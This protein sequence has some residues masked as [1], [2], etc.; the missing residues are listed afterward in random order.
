MRLDYI[1]IVLKQRGVPSQLINRLITAVLKCRVSLVWFSQ[2][3]RYYVKSRGVKQGCPVSPRVFIMMVDEVIQ[4]LVCVLEEIYGIKLEIFTD[5]RATLKAP[6]LMAYADD[7]LLVCEELQ[8]MDMIFKEL[9]ELLSSIGLNL[10]A[11]KTKL[12][13][14]DPMQGDHPN[15]FNIGGLDIERVEKLKYLGSVI[16]A[17]TN[18][19]AAIKTRNYSAFGKYN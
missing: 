2:K 19:P 4:T 1:P 5:S 15:Q 8:M 16:L 9:I 10:N 3:T 18:R 11:T 13:I 7:V 12:L 17:K 6:F 14:R